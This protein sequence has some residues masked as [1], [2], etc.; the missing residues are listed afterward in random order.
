MSYSTIRFNALL[1]LKLYIKYGA[2]LFK[3]RD[4]Y[5]LEHIDN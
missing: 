1:W 5:H 2:I 4:S 3:V